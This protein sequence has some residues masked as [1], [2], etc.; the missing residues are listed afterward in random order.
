MGVK[1]N[2]RII[3]N[4][5]VADPEIGFS[6]NA[7]SVEVKIYILKVGLLFHK[8]ISMLA[9]FCPRAVGRFE[10]FFII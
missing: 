3:T 2:L 7:A 9:Y 1:M 4:N 6:R 8:Q 5:H 10:G